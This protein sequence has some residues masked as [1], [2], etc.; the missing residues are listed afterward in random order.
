MMFSQDP[1]RKRQ[2]GEYAGAVSFE[3][4][5]DGLI[6]LGSQQCV[7]FPEKF[8]A[9]SDELVVPMMPLIQVAVLWLIFD[10]CKK[11]ARHISAPPLSFYV[12]VVLPTCT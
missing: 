11:I 7:D 8:I 10:N 9:T 6:G 4:A 1:L 12:Y 2:D 3:T 5:G